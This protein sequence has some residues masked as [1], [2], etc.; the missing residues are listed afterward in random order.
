M[1]IVS[2]IR[3]LGLILPAGIMLGFPLAWATQPPGAH[4]YLTPSGNGSRDGSSWTNANNSLQ[5][6]LNGLQPG[7]TLETILSE[8]R[9]VSV[10]ERITEQTG[11][12]K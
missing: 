1:M 3:L 9:A 4:Y 11:I 12:K 8:G 5:A 6:R 10:V 7:D 2:A